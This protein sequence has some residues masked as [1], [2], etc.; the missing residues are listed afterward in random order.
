MAAVRFAFKRRQQEYFQQKIKDGHVTKCVSARDV[1]TP[2]EMKRIN[3]YCQIEP[4]MCYRTAY[5]LAN[6]FPDRIKY[7]EGEVTIFNGG[8]GN[9]VINSI[10]LVS[11]LFVLLNLNTDYHIV[12]IKEIEKTADHVAYQV[13][14]NNNNNNQN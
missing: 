13:Y 8:N 4:K 1:F 2:A 9:S 10:E 14:V 5:R 3:Q 12:N 6:L 7:V 11:R